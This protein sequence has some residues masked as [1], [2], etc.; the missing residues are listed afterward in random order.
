MKCWDFHDGPGRIP[1]PEGLA[2]ARRAV[3]FRHVRLDAARRTVRFDD[4]GVELDLGGVGKGYA[5]DLAVARL[6]AF[7]VVPA[8][9]V[10][11]GASSVYALGAP[12]GEA[13]WRLPLRSPDGSALDC[14][15][16]ALRDRSI[17]GSSPAENTFVLDGRRYASILDPRTGLPARGIGASWALAPTATETDVLS[18]TFFIFSPDETRA[19]CEANPEV[20]AIVLPDGAS[21]LLRFG[22]TGN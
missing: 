6:R 16:V 10:H 11:G 22:R 1:S 20:G 15:E 7:R 3:G 5:V 14:G 21:A 4:P 13:A 17:S 12:P 19:Y 2:A 9:L 18:T 8:A